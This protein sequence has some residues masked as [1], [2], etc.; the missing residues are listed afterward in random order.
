M[1]CEVTE[2][3]RWREMQEARIPEFCSLVSVEEARL[4][5]RW[6]EIEVREKMKFKTKQDK[7]V[8]ASHKH[9]C[10][11]TDKQT[12]SIRPTVAKRVE[13]FEAVPLTPVVGCVCLAG[14]AVGRSVPEARHIG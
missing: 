12:N 9:A 7:L 4:S 3:V 1:S 11:I 6:K 10:P 2:T 8:R 14:G 13:R 5:S